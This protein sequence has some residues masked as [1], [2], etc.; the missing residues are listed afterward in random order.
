MDEQSILL[1]CQTWLVQKCIFNTSNL[2]YI[3]Y[4][5]RR[6]ACNQPA[7]WIDVSDVRLS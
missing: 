6:V 7:Y 2:E 1:S 3:P 4:I 5:I